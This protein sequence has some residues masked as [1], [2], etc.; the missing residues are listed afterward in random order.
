MMTT[1][2]KPYLPGL[3]TLAPLSALLQWPDDDGGDGEGGD[4]AGADSGSGSERSSGAVG[5]GNDARLALMARINDQNDEA[6]AD[7]LADIVDIDKGVT[8]PFRLPT[9]G[10]DDAPAQ[11]TAPPAD[12]EGGET[13]KAATPVPKMKVDGVEV[14]VT[15]EL[16]AKAQK[17]AQA[18]KYLQ[19]AAEARKASTSATPPADSAKTTTPEQDAAEAERLALEEER[20][21]VRAIQVGTEEEAVAALRKLKGQ[22]QAN[23]QQ[24]SRIADERLNFKE[25]INWFNGEY[26]DL[27]SNPELHSIVMQRDSALVAAGDTRTY[28]ER[29]DAIGKEVR[30]WRDNLIKSTGAKLPSEDPPAPPAPALEDKEVRKANAP[31]MPRGAGGKAPAK[32]EEDDGEEDPRDVIAEMAKQRG[33]PQWAKGL[34]VQ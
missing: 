8:E 23:F 2:R 26:K 1:N 18:D 19:E 27:V 10:N 6:Q 16:L 20:A 31:S 14:D 25:A 29:Y 5:T 13:D 22:T 11:K 28:K 30:E 4:D 15:P 12:S 34:P 32:A 9:P 33:G 24:M 21:L 7:Q 3:M 17:I